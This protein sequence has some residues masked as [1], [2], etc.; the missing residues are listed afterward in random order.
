M[1]RVVATSDSSEPIDYII[2]GSDTSQL[3]FGVNQNTGDIIVDGFVDRELQSEHLFTVEVY[4]FVNNRQLKSSVPVTITV[5]DKNDNRPRFS[6][7]RY[8]GQVAENRPSNTPIEPT[9]S[10]VIQATDRDNGLNGTILY[11]IMEDNTPF[12]ID[13]NGQ[14]FTTR[15]FDREVQD[16]FT[17]T[18]IA[19]DQGT[20]PLT[21]SSFVRATIAILDT[22]DHSPMFEQQQYSAQ[23]AENAGSGDPVVTVN[24]TD[25][26]LGEN[27][28]ISY[29]L[30]GSTLFAVDP[31]TGVVSV[32]GTLDRETMPEHE[33]TVD[34]YDGANRDS[35]QLV[36]TVMDVNDEPP[37]FNTS[38][39]TTTV[40]EN[41]PT[42]TPLLSVYAEDPDQVGTVT[43]SVVGPSRDDFTINPISGELRFRV[44]P[45]YEEFQQLEIQVAASDGVHEVLETVTVFITDMND[46]KPSFTMDSFS[47]SVQE[48]RAE[49]TNVVK[50]S[51]TDEDSGEGG[52]VT[53]Q[54]VG[55]KIGNESVSDVSQLPFQ[56]TTQQSGLVVTTQELNRE[57]VSEYT[58]TV[59]ASDRGDPS[60]SSNTTVIITVLDDND[61]SPVF[62]QPMY[63]AEL[64]ESS[65][66]E[67]PVVT[68]RA[69]DE[70]SG[71]NA[72]I[73]YSLDTSNNSQHFSI[74]REL[75]NIAV[76]ESLDFET[77]PSYHLTVIASDRGQVARS[78][79]AIIVISITDENDNRPTFQQSSYLKILSEDVEIDSS[80][81]Q[82]I[83]RDLDSG[84]AASIV[85]SIIDGNILPEFRLDPN[86][87]ILFVNS[88]LDY[89]RQRQYQFRVRAENTGDSSQFDT[90]RVN[91]T[92]TDV[93]D[94]VPV[95]VPPNPV[96]RVT[97]ER[98]PEITIG[99]VSA[100]DPDSVTNPD[101][102][103]FSIISG[104]DHGFFSLDTDSG[105]LVTKTTFDRE[106]K[107]M[108]RLT[109]TADDGGSPSQT[110]T[111]QVTVVIDDINDNDP[112]AGHAD[113]FVYVLAEEFVPGLIGQVNANDPDVVNTHVY[114]L[115]RDPPM[116]PSPFVLNDN[117]TIESTSKPPFS[118]FQFEVNV[119]DNSP[120]VTCTVRISVQGIEREVAERSI[121]M[122]LRGSSVHEF[123]EEKVMPFTSGGAPFFQAV[124]SDSESPFVV[125]AQAV[126]EVDEIIDVS[127]AV[128]LSDGTGYVDQELVRH[129][130]HTSRSQF[131]SSGIGINVET[132]LPDL[133][134]SE[135]CGANGICQNVL[136][137]VESTLLSL[138]P[139]YAIVAPSPLWD[140]QC[141]CLP[142]VS[143]R[144]CDS[145]SVDYC[146]LTPCPSP[147]TC[148]NAAARATCSCPEG[149]EY[150]NGVCTVNQTACMQKACQNGASCIVTEEGLSCACPQGYVGSRCTIEANPPN[151]CLFAAC[152]AGSTCTYSHV[153]FTCSCPP[154]QSGAQC[155]NATAAVSACDLN[156]CQAGGTCT[157]VGNGFSCTCPEGYTGARCEVYL[158]ADS[159]TQPSAC[160]SAECTEEEDCVEV[161]GEVS[162]LSP[163]S[164]NPCLHGGTC[165]RQLPG[166][167]CDCLE[168]YRGPRCEV[169]LASFARDSF[170]VFPS[171]HTPLNSTIYLEFTTEAQSGLLFLNGRYDDKGTDFISLE[172][173]Q[174]RLKYSL[175]R[176]GT[177]ETVL[178]YGQGVLNDREWHT[179][180]AGFNASVSLIGRF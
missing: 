88:G 170:A 79:T 29:S 107:A 101:D 167:A 95:F 127:F 21:S 160:D 83:A 44:P 32:S 10:S 39:Y 82:V 108:Y 97:E 6:V 18:V 92:L 8:Q 37:V 152:Q 94:E 30:Q 70:D 118:T 63:E 38:D 24:A 33:L 168:Q 141:V 151:L 31:E 112:Q 17:F 173:L 77:Q 68:V 117:G 87:G 171:I 73:F 138:S 56:L 85:Y 72:M 180:V 163:C 80:L 99:T 23:V 47:G 90:A 5:L 116:L 111:T 57:A 98:D 162:C 113:I 14:I 120:V 3:P 100:S 149:S 34:A 142:G 55:G 35:V 164:P 132:E 59:T 25:R 15:G 177:E 22:N 156:P 131:A 12:I 76:A 4:T 2:A 51:A 140:Y 104:N 157:A 115:L 155:V 126:D 124:V 121:I 133:C 179:V 166:F 49:F 129:I 61:H 20:P 148:T 136:I 46:E 122:R 143:G 69:T 119:M 58:L 26:D 125:S 60:L 109:V 27:A 13:N 110:A 28:D 176:G 54:I 71:S 16:Q 154:G 78:G 40:E 1:G 42:D 11:R 52:I 153:G 103:T 62:L 9:G 165:V 145:G 64:S 123:L 178:E 102:I 158:F 130:V 67:T 172:L 50:L 169:T 66:L 106:V 7:P 45:D 86:T 161:N 159:V 114:T 89:E 150:Q 174:G 48:N 146:S 53:Y 135:P 36:V 139:A 43:Y 19:V 144:H 75:G 74:D 137:D 81:L 147:M 65:P 41:A 91:I 134:V 128:P 105:V 175:S 93:N 96:F 84:D